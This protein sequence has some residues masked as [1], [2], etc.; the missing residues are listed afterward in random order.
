MTEFEP[1][2]IIVELADRRAQRICGR[3]CRELY[4]LLPPFDGY[5]PDQ[6]TEAAAHLNDRDNVAATVLDGY[7]AAIDSDGVRSRGRVRRQ[8][9][10]AEHAI[11]VGEPLSASAV[12]R[13]G[14]LV[15][16]A[17]TDRSEA[18]HALDELLRLAHLTLTD[19]P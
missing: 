1:A 17:V 5:L 12:A 7:R 9:E 6:I 3:T 18:L 4:E 8:L 13:L 19:Q 2:G 11:A 10:A 16:V 14:R 15:Q